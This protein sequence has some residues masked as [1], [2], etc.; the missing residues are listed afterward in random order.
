MPLND[1]VNNRSFSNCTGEC[2]MLFGSN[3]SGMKDTVRGALPR[4]I[5][6][7]RSGVFVLL[8]PTDPMT[9][10]QKLGNPTLFVPKT[11]LL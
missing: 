2:P 4:K 11:T 9:I 1:H 3:T 7:H 6:P 5:T 10:A 8:D